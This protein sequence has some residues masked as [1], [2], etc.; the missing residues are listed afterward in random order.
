VHPERNDWNFGNERSL[1]E[2]Y[3]VTVPE[4]FDACAKSVN[5]G[6]E[7]NGLHCKAS[8]E[9]ANDGIELANIA[10]SFQAKSVNGGVRV[11]LI[12]TSGSDPLQSQ[13]V[14]DSIGVALRDG[15]GAKIQAQTVNAEIRTDFPIE[16][17]G[18]IGKS[19]K[20]KINRDGRKLSLQAINGAIRIKKAI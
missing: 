9:T 8:A 4:R 20:G 14:N 10:G 13:T 18:V 6:V 16:V 17:R 11:E 1:K 2:T 5:G 15:I 12:E 7:I 3:T 19:L